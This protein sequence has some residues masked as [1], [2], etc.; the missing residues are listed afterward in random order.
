[1]NNCRRGMLTGNDRRRVMVRM[2]MSW[3][4][5]LPEDDLRSVLRE[6]GTAVFMSF[7]LSSLYSG[8]VGFWELQEGELS[9][10]ILSLSLSDS[11]LAIAW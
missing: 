9:V 8:G 7:S 1:M 4:S 5:M 10:H 3:M 11:S 2:G 6:C